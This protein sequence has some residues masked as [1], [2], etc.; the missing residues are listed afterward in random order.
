MGPVLL[1]VRMRQT[2]QPK[3]ALPDL[4]SPI[5]IHSIIEIVSTRFLKINQLNYK[6]SF[7]IKKIFSA[8][9][10]VINPSCKSASIALY[11][12]NRASP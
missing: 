8:K 12:R 1:I 5:K 3:E 6:I 4:E 7:Q 2:I 9:P 11:D 10:L